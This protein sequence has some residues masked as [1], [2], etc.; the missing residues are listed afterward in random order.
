MHQ[1]MMAFHVLF[2]VD[3]GALRRVRNLGLHV[4]DRTPALK[5]FFMRFATGTIPD[6]PDLRARRPVIVTG[7]PMLPVRSFETASAGNPRH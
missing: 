2:G 4:A 3:L 1:T 5:R 7:G 6:L